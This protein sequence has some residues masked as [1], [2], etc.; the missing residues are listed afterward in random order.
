MSQA[1]RVVVVASMLTLWAAR[2]A[3]ADWTLTAY[4]GA[5]RTQETSL[6]LVRPGS[7]THVTLSP[8]HYDSAS[9][10]APPYYGYRVGWFPKST[11]FGVEGEFI[12]L[13]VI[14][15]TARVTTVDG[16]F[17]GARVTGRRPMEEIIQRFSISHGMNLVLVNA[18]VRRGVAMSA[19]TPTPRLVLTGRFG[20]GAS[21]PHPESTVN[22]MTFESYEWGA[23]SMQGGA[24]IELR[25][26][27]RAY[28]TGEYKL[29]RTVQD[30]TIPG[31]S[32]R[33][34]LVT[35]HLVGGLV[36]HL[37]RSPNVRTAD[38]IPRDAGDSTGPEPLAF[39]GEP[40]RERSTRHAPEQDLDQSATRPHGRGARTRP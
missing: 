39:R 33:T 25:L 13:K 31:G 30:V 12:H 9:F 22:G 34:P 21:I 38:S 24:G 16:T 14:A 18:V 40:R 5:S 17:D 36:T 11:W 27:G 28:L 6:T 19:R 29:S 2:E 32:V 20:A 15:D 3:A 35:H 7:D 10:E 1:R 37:G 23:F 8:V 4:L 26:G